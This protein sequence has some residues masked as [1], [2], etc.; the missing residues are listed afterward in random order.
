MKLLVIVKKVD[1]D[2]FKIYERKEFSRCISFSYETAGLLVKTLNSK[3]E[4]KYYRLIGVR[5]IFVD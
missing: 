2:G 3:N 5:Q 1:D 4:E